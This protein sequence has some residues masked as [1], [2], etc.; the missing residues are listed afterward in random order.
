M[1]AGYA[2]LLEELTRGV[3]GEDL[4]AGLTAGSI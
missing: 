4:A 3:V 1:S 2:G